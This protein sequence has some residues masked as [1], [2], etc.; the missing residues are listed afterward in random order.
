[1]LWENPQPPQTSSAMP[2][3]RLLWRRIINL[4]WATLKTR[5]S[6]WKL[7]VER[8]KILCASTY[9]SLNQTTLTLNTWWSS[10][11]KLW[12]D[13]IVATKW[14]RSTSMWESFSSVRLPLFRSS[15]GSGKSCAPS[16]SVDNS[17]IKCSKR[18]GMTWLKSTFNLINSQFCDACSSGALLKLSRSTGA[19]IDCDVV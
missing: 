6:S 5:N 16:V 11:S 19:C 7:C 9:E 17:N 13:G 2:T 12:F 14:I 10:C 18:K 4:K 1:M 3:I 15:S 8:V